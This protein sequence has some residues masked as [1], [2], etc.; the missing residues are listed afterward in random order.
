MKYGGSW[1]L[2]LEKHQQ[3]GD[4]TSRKGLEAADH[5]VPSS[6]AVQALQKGRLGTEILWGGKGSRAGLSQ[7][8]S[9][10]MVPLLSGLQGQAQLV[11]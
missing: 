3:Y 7:A 1:F 9:T 4:T 6:Y 5:T 2:S 10:R 8:R 11:S